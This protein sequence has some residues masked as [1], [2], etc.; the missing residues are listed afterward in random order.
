MRCSGLGL[1]SADLT[2]THAANSFSYIKKLLFSFESFG[3]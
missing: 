2:E 3:T 1:A